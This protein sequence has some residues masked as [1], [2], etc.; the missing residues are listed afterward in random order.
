MRDKLKG[1]YVIIDP[2]IESGRD[3]LAIAQ[4]ALA[5]GARLIQLRDKRQEK[6][7]QLETARGLARLCR[8]AKALFIIN[9]HIDLAM[10]SGADGVHV[11]PKD[12]PVE[13]VRQLVPSTM[14]IG[15]STNT[16]KSAL[17][18]EAA[19]ADYVSVG[20]LF[21]T[22]SKT[23]TRPATLETLQLV[24]NSVSLPICA[25]GGIDSSNIESVLATETEMVAVISAVISKPDIEEA[26]RRLA[27]H[28]YS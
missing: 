9:D 1:L 25:I 18:A 8:Q 5:G 15:C 11:G 22:S 16:A 14:L 24:R 20:C 21:P 12:L 6:R 7:L 10:A 23:D 13:T 2:E 19:G 27:T 28:F 26:T 17:D 4:A 3:E